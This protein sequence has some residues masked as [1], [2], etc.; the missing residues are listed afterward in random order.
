MKPLVIHQTD[1]FH[2]NHN[3]PDD[4]WDLACQYALAFL[5]YIQLEGVVIDYPPIVFGDPSIQAVNQLNYIT[6]KYV[7]VAVGTSEA[8]T[9]CKD[10]S[11]C[12]G[13]VPEFSGV[14]LILDT[15]EKS[16]SGV[17]IHI[18]G[19]C[20]DVAIASKINPSLFKEKC[21]AIYLNAGASSPDSEPEYNVGLDPYSYSCIF[22]I[23]CPI[24]WMPCFEHAPK[25]P[26]WEFKMGQYGTFY[27]FEQGEILPYL[28]EKM[29]N[30]FIYALGNVTDSKW[31]SYLKNTVNKR[32][33]DYYCQVGRSMY[34]TAGIFH[35]AGKSVTR[36]GE[37]TDHCDAGE[38]AVF[39]FEPVELSCSQKGF[40]KWNITEKDTNRFIF[41]VKD[42]S[43]YP[44]AMTKAMKSLLTKIP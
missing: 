9:A 19:S 11:P 24:Y 14:N 12:R 16:E 43:K 39:T 25:A 2:S 23:D 42:L 3:D 10:Y 6:G 8:M 31:L 37:L 15:L 38:D 44:S 18:V 41:K 21:K 36:D 32:M 34:S 1:L 26:E 7:P 5:G 13:F 20:R 27:K 33:L 28:S 22:G 4:H 35:G 30:Y 29:Q 40:V 17:I